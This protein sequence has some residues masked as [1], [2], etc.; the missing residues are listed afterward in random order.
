M[1][2]INRRYFSCCPYMPTARQDI[3]HIQLELFTQ[4]E[5]NIGH[6][7]GLT[8]IQGLQLDFNCGL[9]LDIPSGNFHVRVS[10]FLTHQVFFNASISD[11]RLISRE[12]FAINWQVDIWQ[13]G[14]MIFSHS[15]APAGQQV[16]FH[17]SSG[18]I[19][20]TLAFMPYTRLYRDKFNCQV[21]CFVAE[22][23]REIVALLYPDIPQI[24]KLPDDAYATFYL[25][26]WADGN[27]GA[28]VNGRTYPLTKMAGAIIGLH[29][30]APQAAIRLQ[31]PRTIN[32]PYICIGVQ[33]STP[34]KGWLY[35]NGWETVVSAL[36][37]KGYRV[38]C[39]DR[40]TLASTDGYTVT[41]PSNAENFTGDFSL[42]ERAKLLAHAT[43][44]IGLSSGLSW[45]AHALGC[46]VVLISGITEDDYEFPTPYRVIN[47][48][49]CHG[50]FNSSCGDNFM[51]EG[52]ICPHY[53]GTPRELECSRLIHPDMVLAASNIA[54]T[55]RIAP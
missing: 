53:Q 34:R 5:E 13:D 8:D 20:D 18:A 37:K 44:F 1:N 52:I 40:H 31:C 55:E 36:I 43:C 30:N 33:G 14:Q 49:V 17:C 47:R 24:T 39:I 29:G 42:L 25:G 3:N 38:I 7:R 27:Y 41:C 15:F 12:K 9:R 46:P 50:C 28:P 45:L 51:K 35:P 16:I 19:G 6:V 48:L 21:L 26:T 10:D 32:E 4:M 11:T 54:I 22:P 2:K 23:L